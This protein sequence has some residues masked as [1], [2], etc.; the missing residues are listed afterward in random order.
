MFQ[1]KFLWPSLENTIIDLSHLNKLFCLI[2]YLSLKLFIFYHS[3][4][5]FQGK[6]DILREKIGIQGNEFKFYLQLFKL[7]LFLINSKEFRSFKIGCKEKMAK[8]KIASAFGIFF[9]ALFVVLLLLSY[10]VDRFIRNCLENPLEP[11]GPIGCRITW[12]ESRLV[13][14]Q[15]LL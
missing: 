8:N 3:I 15:F 14:I 12:R 2:N 6:D 4:T 13:V 7:I 9:S 5:I 11:S 1:K 10:S